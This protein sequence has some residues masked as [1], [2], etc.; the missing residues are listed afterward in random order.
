[1][2]TNDDKVK[3]LATKIKSAVKE[4]KEVKRAALIWMALETYGKGEVTI[5]K[6]LKPLEDLEIIEV[7]PTTIKWVGD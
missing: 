2:I 1:M 3:L 6:I 7:T 4:Q 5:N